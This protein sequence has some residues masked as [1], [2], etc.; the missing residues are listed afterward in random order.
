MSNYKDILVN[1]RFQHISAVVC[2]GGGGRVVYSC[3][4]RIWTGEICKLT[5]LRDETQPLVI[6]SCN[7]FI[8]KLNGSRE[9]DAMRDVV[10]LIN[11]GHFPDTYIC[12]RPL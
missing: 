5:S 3:S 8:L 9:C 11:S 2:V 1:R 12:P 7:A 6:A 4:V 10:L